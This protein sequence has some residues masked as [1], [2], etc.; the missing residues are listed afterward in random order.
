MLL[1][2]LITFDV[3]TL[4]KKVTEIHSIEHAGDLAK[5]EMMAQLAKEFIAPIEREDIVELSQK[6]DDITDSIE[7]VLMKIHMFNITSI[8]PEVLEFTKLITKCC[9][10]LKVALQEFPQ[11]KKSSSSLKEK[12]IAVSYL[13]E[14]GDRLY[15]RTV[16]N[17]YVN[18]RDPL[19][20]FIWTE[21]YELLEKCCDNCAHTADTVE[22][23]IM[24]NS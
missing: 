14:E 1:N 5:H 9:T 13:E 6:I 11:Y 17:L 18:Y 10:A 24:K 4:D 23:V 8:K 19:E 20:L 15:Y 12:I 7:E 21:L 2:S 3:N 16:R 22:S